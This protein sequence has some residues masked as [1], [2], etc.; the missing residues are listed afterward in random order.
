MLIY[1][2]R[3]HALA[4]ITAI[5]TFPLI[6]MGGLVTSHGAG[7]SVPDWP[8]SYGYNMFLFPISQWRGGIFFEHTH[9]LMG[10]VVGFCSLL[11]V[12]SAWGPGQKRSARWLLWIGAISAALF[13]GLHGLSV[14]LLPPGGYLSTR[15]RLIQGMMIWSAVALVLG[16]A[17]FTR[18]PEPRRWVR[19][20]ATSVLGAVIFQGI[21]G[22]LRVVWVNLDLAIVHACVAQA[23]FCLAALMTI[24]TSRWWLQAPD[25]SRAADARIGKRLMIAGMI[26]V[27]A[28]YLQLIVGAMMRHFQAGLAVPTLPLAYGQ[29]FPAT[30]ADALEKINQLR[31]WKLHLPAVSAWQIWLHMGHRIGAIV[32]TVVLSWLIVLSLRRKWDYP[33]LR[34]LAWLLI[35]LLL[36]QLTLGVLTVL[37]RK[38]A[39][40]ASSHVAVGALILVTTFALTVRG[41][42]LYS[43]HT[44]PVEAAAK[45][46]VAIS[47]GAVAV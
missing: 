18:N 20:L 33:G 17:T 32:V 14:T 4:M 44:R 47:S 27:V 35:A 1:R 21:L 13:A 42:R 28:I 10:T 23:F 24:V 2:P 41:I 9:R 8:N 25:L 29:I 19:W 26:A 43:G 36:T 11:L 5:A 39:D 22:G 46:P 15:S 30:G 37:Y 31:A 3:L 40:I 45:A 6:F 7:M 34:S 38:P 12:L 16:C